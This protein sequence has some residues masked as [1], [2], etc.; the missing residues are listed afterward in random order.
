MAISNAS[1][2]FR[3]GVCTSTTRPQAPFN[4]QVIYETDTKQTLVWQGSTW[5]ML[6]DA[7]QPPGLQLIKSQT[8][9]TGV[10]SVTVTD[11]FSANYNAYRI[12]IEGTVVSSPGD[13][14]YITLSGSGGSTYYWAGNYQAYSGGTSVN[15]GNAAQPTGIWMGITGAIS[16]FSADLFNPFEEKATNYVGNYANNTWRGNTGGQ[17]NNAVSHTGFTITQLGARTLTGGTIRVYGYR[18]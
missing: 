1:S 13:S 16:S 7:N 8:I 10:S 5:V 3:P 18:N 15:I 11:A 4:G 17:D 9:G 14:V 12:I 2:G 6:T